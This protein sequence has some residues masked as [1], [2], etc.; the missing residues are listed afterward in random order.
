M[1]GLLLAV[2]LIALPILRMN[3]IVILGVATYWAYYFWGAGELMNVVYDMWD[4]S[5]REVLLSI[6]L[7]IMAGTIMS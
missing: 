6:P 2:I 7:Y 4:A 1:N 5:N 3:I